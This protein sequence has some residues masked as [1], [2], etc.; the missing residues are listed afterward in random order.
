LLGALLCLLL[1]AAAASAQESPYFIT[2]DHHMEEP[3]SIELSFEPVLGTPKEGGRAAAANVE[4]E[5]GATGWWTTSLYIDGAAGSGSAAM[6]TGV[7]LENRFRLLMDERLV[8]PVL[9]V[10]Y[11]D[12][13]AADRVTKE[14]V[15]FDSWR[16]FAEPLAQSRHER[17]RELET[18]L[19][20]SSNVNGWNIAGNAIAEKN[21]AGD[22]WEL[23][24][25]VAASRPL[26][27]A[28]AARD[29]VACAEN[30]TV[31]VELYGGL[32]DQRRV[33]TSGTAHY[34]APTVAWSLSRGV[35]LRFSPGWGLTGDSNRSFVRFGISYEGRIR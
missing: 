9:Y 20:L 33:T 12:I 15:G 2:Y 32:G 31:G 7:R 26:A 34:L 25:A 27:L 35:T 19:I 29:C 28:A 22:P 17:E 23:G 3:G 21:L 18:K 5:Y 8:N 30:V 16:D 13:T 6:F 1:G 10:E 4:I 14:V 11:E 24:Y